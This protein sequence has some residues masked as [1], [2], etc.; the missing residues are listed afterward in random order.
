M[1]V[2]PT[3]DAVTSPFDLISRERFPQH[4]LIPPTAERAGRPG[5][6]RGFESGSLCFYP[7]QIF[8]SF[9]VSSKGTAGQIYE[10][11]PRVRI[12]YQI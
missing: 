4:S 7:Y 1:L 12:Y 8:I 9:F 10:F 6:R 2:N 11:P 5:N 3:E